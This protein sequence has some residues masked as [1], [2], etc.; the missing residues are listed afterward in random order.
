MPMDF[1]YIEELEKKDSIESLHLAVLE[2]KKK[3]NEFGRLDRRFIRSLAD[4]QNFLMALSHADEYII[5]QQSQLSKNDL[6]SIIS[7][8]KQAI[9]QIDD[10]K[11]ELKL[12]A[13]VKKILRF[14]FG[15][16]VIILFIWFFQATAV[17]QSISF[18]I[19]DE[20][21]MTIY[22]FLAFFAVIALGFVIF[23]ATL[24]FLERNKGNK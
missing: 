2:C 11:D 12:R 23:I 24:A 13:G 17:G 5:G 10:R 14:I 1:S 6:Y 22:W 15:F 19:V 20:I 9:V 8:L 18:F 21:S 3:L 16:V 7:S 4:W